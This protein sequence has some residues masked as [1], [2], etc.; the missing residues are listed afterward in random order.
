[1]PK[2]WQYFTDEEV[3]GL[4]IELVSLLDLARDRAKVPFILTSGFRTPEAN[5]AAG[6]KD[7]SA[8]LRGLAVDI[9]CGDSYERFQII[10]ALYFVG[11]RRIGDYEDHVHADIDTTLPQDVLWVA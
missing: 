1:M 11:F 10:R 2:R 9:R 5:W 4:D 7:N 3:K 6:G 8:H